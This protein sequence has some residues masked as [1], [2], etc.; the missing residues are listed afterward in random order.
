MNTN[1]VNRFVIVAFLALL[2][3][4]PVIQTA[5]EVRRGE[6]PL[7]LSLLAALPTQANLRSFEHAMEDASVVARTLR[8]WVRGGQFLALR[9]AGEKAVVGRDGW[10]FYQPGVARLTQRPKPSDPLPA[11]AFAVVL[12][13]RNQL[14]ARGIRLVVVPVPDKE[15]VYPDRLARGVPPPARIIS[16]ETREFLKRCEGAGVE[17]VDLFALYRTARADTTAPLYLVQDSHWSPAG[18]QLAAAAVAE[19]ILQRGWLVRGPAGY[20][21]RPVPVR[22]HGDLVRML[23]SPMIE[24]NLQPEA[25]ACEQVVRH[26]TGVVYSAE[27]QADVLVLGDSFLRIYQQDAPGGAGFIAH[28]ARAL[29]RPVSSLVNDGGGATLVRQ[30]LFRRPNMLAGKKVVVWEFVERDL[31]WAAEGWP[32]VPL[33]P[34][35]GEASPSPVHP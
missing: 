23:C 1:P 9:E 11:Q 8:P 26:G 5:V 14:A 18:M 4:V 34:V 10:L 29:G 2:A 16:A 6:R 25:I 7:A 28:F 19:R 24:A 3:G 21:G 13:F 20:D 15:S 27:A 17:L 32:S 22:R 33:P 12:D 30:E 35:A 31:R